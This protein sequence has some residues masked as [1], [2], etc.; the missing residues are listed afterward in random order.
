M[1]ASTTRTTA[2]GDVERVGATVYNNNNF[3][4]RSFVCLP[5]DHYDGAATIE[6]NDGT[7]WHAVHGRQIPA[8]ASPQI[9]RISNGLIRLSWSN[10]DD[11]ITL[12]HYASAAWATV[13][14]FLHRPALS[15]QRSPRLV[16]V[17][18]N[19][20]EAVVVQYTMTAYADPVTIELHRGALHGS[21]L[22]PSGRWRLDVSPNEAATSTTGGLYA[23]SATAEGHRWVLASD[24]SFTADT[25]NGRI[26]DTSTGPS[27]DHIA[28]IG[29][30]P[31]GATDTPTTA[32]E[33][34][35]GALSAKQVVISP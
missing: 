29:V 10:A 25:T 2:T 6:Y 28:M 15:E 12:E 31:S 4:S 9:I 1:P 35:W 8:V 33:D 20:P 5:S 13:G 11:L 21:V 23:T 16:S 14:E 17:L 27:S 22:V 34:W 18:R 24:Q 30:D 7:N 19:S 3:Q 32:I 26:G